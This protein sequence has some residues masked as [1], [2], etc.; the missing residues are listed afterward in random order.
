MN[1]RTVS[2]WPSD[3]QR[4]RTALLNNLL[5]AATAVGLLLLLVY[6]VVLRTQGK[7]ARDIVGIMVP[8][9]VGW[10]VVA[11][12]WAWRRLSHN[13]RASVFLALTW[14]LGVLLF[15]RGGLPGGGR[16]WILLLPVFGLVLMGQTAGIV[17]GVVSILTYAGFA[18]AFNQKWIPAPDVAADLTALEPWIGEG[19]GFLLVT[20]ILVVLLWLSNRDWLEALRG[21][22]VANEQLQV[23]TRKL[24]MANIQLASQAS[25]L[26]A[27]AE[28]A[29]IGSTTLDPDTLAREVVNHI[30]EGFAP[31]GVYFVG[32]FLL[33]EA[34]G[35]ALL[36]AATGE[37]GRL[38]LEM[39]YTVE[40]DE[41]TTVGW[42]IMHQQARVAQNLQE[43][44]VRLDALPMPHTR[45]EIALPLRSRGR[46]LGALNVQSTREAAFA[47]ADAAILQMTTDV[48]ATAIDNARLLIQTQAALEEA[49]A[50]HRRYLIEAWREFLA[51]KPVSQ[52]D[53]RKPGVEIGDGDLLRQTQ[54]AAVA[55]QRTVAASSPASESEGAASP[56]AALVVPL[57]LR[58]QVIGTMALHETRR[59]RLWTNDEVALAE[60]IAEQVALTVENLRLMDEAQRGVVRERAIREISDQMQRAADME[61]LV[62]I[63][64]E[65]L[66]RI[67]G[68]SR[69]YVR[70]SPE[71]LLLSPE[72]RQVDE[73]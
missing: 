72:S 37:A 40:V 35:K 70:L 55:H 26:R 58:G 27:T 61:T 30:Q 12:A 6:P 4:S 33:D 23:Q 62:R 9:V 71:A 66:N 60:T 42:S 51:T 64:A 63:A 41:A 49:Q 17:S 19:V 22:G 2:D 50:A 67:L 73:G 57:K 39:G 68:G 48:I 24:E 20:V 47:D 13:I 16:T 18:L 46:V 7:G 5:L 3:I 43:G 14:V 15:Y 59:Q 21:A 10:L 25:Q 31:L 44:S 45:S 34:Q 54:R 36:R 38:L 8:F 29:R 1:I 69:T 52:V 65:E 28:I 32:L 56:Q 53:Y 11:V